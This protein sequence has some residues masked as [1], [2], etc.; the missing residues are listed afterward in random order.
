MT[1]WFY[2]L[3]QNILLYGENVLDENYLCAILEGDCKGLE[4]F[5]WI[6]RWQE[7]QITELNQEFQPSVDKLL[8]TMPIIYDSQY[9]TPAS[10]LI[11]LQESLSIIRSK[12]KCCQEN[13]LVYCCGPTSATMSIKLI[14][15][16]S[17]PIKPREV[18]DH[19]HV[20][21]WTLTCTRC[22]WTT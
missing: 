12:P 2:N 3:H 8:L 5:Y 21:T 19:H 16:P 6:N 11:W 18:S 10:N 22:N 7:Y 13:K 20:R 4:V 9:W 1:V 14:Q 17:A 15:I